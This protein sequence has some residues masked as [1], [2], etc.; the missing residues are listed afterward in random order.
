[1]NGF[2]HKFRGLNRINV[3]SSLPMKNG[4]RRVVFHIELSYAGMTC[5]QV[6]V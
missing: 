4:V 1:M 6:G 3:D 5:V 2:D